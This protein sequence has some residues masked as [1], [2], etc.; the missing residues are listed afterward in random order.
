MIR[1][2][3]VTHENMSNNA[4]W[5]ESLQTNQTIKVCIPCIMFIKHNIF[6]VAQR[7]TLFLNN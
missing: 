1:D 5:C 4:E 6:M 2:I 7:T 3:R